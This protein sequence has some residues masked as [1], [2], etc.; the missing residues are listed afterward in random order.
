[1]LKAIISLLLLSVVF[2]QIQIHRKGE[3]ANG[4]G[5]LTLVNGQDMQYYGVFTMGTPA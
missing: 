4:A 2:G 5:N 3:R 1:M